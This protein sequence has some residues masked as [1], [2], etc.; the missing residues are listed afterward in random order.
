MPGDLREFVKKTLNSRKLS[1][2]MF[3]FSSN[4]YLVSLVLRDFDPKSFE[5]HVVSHK[6]IHFSAKI[7]SRDLRNT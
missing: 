7:L 2:S 6:Q 5:T 4:S 1:G 3:L